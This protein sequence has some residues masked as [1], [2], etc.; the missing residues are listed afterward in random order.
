MYTFTIEASTLLEFK[1]RVR[2]INDLV[3]FEPI[4]VEYEKQ[5]TQEKTKRRKKET[6]Q[7]VEDTQLTMDLTVKEPAVKL[8]TK[9]E[10]YDKLQ[11]ITAKFGLPS[12]RETLSKFKANRISDLKEETFPEFLVYCNELL[13]RDL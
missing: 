3:N 10:V 2:E 9:E 8:P 5:V 4:A 12:S 6:A 7:D 11:E 13:K 1:T